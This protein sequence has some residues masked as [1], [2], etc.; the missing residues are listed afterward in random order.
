MAQE[1]I[2]NWHKD[3]KVKKYKGGI[4]EYIIWKKQ[5]FQLQLGAQY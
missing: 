4:L 5:M 3:E 2:K 1:I